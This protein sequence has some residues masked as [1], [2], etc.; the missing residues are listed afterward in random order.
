MML[1]TVTLQTLTFLSSWY[2][3]FYQQAIVNLKSIP[4]KTM[5]HLQKDLVTDGI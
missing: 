3:F 2:M 5:L 1:Q 4:V